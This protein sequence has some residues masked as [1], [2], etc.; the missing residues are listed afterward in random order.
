VTIHIEELRGPPEVQIE[1]SPADVE[2]EPVSGLHARATS[3]LTR[4]L[5]TSKMAV[6]SIYAASIIS[7][8]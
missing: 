4:T 7:K 5:S 1:K 6:E 8:L 2:A 3:I